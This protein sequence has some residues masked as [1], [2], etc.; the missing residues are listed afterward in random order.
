MKTFE[1]LNTEKK[2]PGSQNINIKYDCV[3]RP[4]KNFYMFLNALL[5]LIIKNGTISTT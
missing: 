4:K 2:R 3:N 1:S 5:P